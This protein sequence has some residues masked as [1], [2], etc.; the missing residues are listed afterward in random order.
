MSGYGYTLDNPRGAGI[1]TIAAIATPPGRGGIGII[2]VSGSIVPR[3]FK[4]IL[5]KESLLS[6]RAVFSTF[7]SQNEAVDQ[8]LALYFPSPHSFTGEPV[9]ELQTHGSPVILERLLESLLEEGV[10]LAEPGEF[11]KRAYLND[12]MDLA[13]AEAVSDL[14][15]ATTRKSAQMAFRSLQGDFSKYIDDLSNKILKLRMYVEAAIDFPDEEV[16]FLQDGV[17][18]ERLSMLTIALGQVLLSAEQGVILQ[19]GVRLVI[20]GEPNAGKSSLLNALAE[21]DVAIVTSIPGTTR[22]VVRETIQIQGVPFHLIDTAGIRETQDEIELAG[23]EK[24]HQN[25]KLADILLWMVDETTILNDKLVL[26]NLLLEKT[27]I[28]LNKVDLTQKEVGLLG[29]GRLMVRISAKTGQGLDVLKQKMIQLA[30]LSDESEGLFIAR[31]RHV[32][33]LKQTLLHV[34][35]A[36]LQLEKYKAGELVAEELKIAHQFLGSIVGL[37]SSDDL[38]GEIFSSFC[39]GK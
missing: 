22:D 5:K 25:I 23:I 24:T 37:V 31:K 30:G 2:R 1:D 8:G 27:I 16:D 3:L 4:K 13:Q 29:E 32:V 33:A 19:E 17:I 39:I 10:R 28:V 14:I 21:N 26:P 35:K 12:R 6:R 7:Y 18:L 15:S 34:K 38:L 11:S 36:I 9:L 20:A